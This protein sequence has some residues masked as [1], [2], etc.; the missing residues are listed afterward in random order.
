MGNKPG[1]VFFNGGLLHRHH[2]YWTIGGKPIGAIISGGEMAHVV[3]VA[4]EERHS[5][6]FPYT[7]ASITCF[8]R[9]DGALIYGTTLGFGEIFNFKNLVKKLFLP[10]DTS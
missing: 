3:N 8:T 7:R 10:T 6:E 5:G 2:R 4:E 9:S 1:D